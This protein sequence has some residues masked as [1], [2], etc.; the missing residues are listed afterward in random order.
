MRRRS[1]H[2]SEGLGL[3]RAE[4]V[5]RNSGVEAGPNATG[6]GQQITVGIVKSAPAQMNTSSPFSPP[7]GGHRQGYSASSVRSPPPERC[8]HTALCG[9]SD[10]DFCCG[11]GTGNRIQHLCPG[12]AKHTAPCPPCPA[13]RFRCHSSEG[14]RYG[15]RLWNGQN[16][17]LSAGTARPAKG[18]DSPAQTSTHTVPASPDSVFRRRCSRTSLLPSNKDRLSLGIDAIKIIQMD[19]ES[20]L[21]KGFRH[22]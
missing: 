15:N 3:E 2:R 1:S 10:S 11:G 5:Q 14:H 16:I 20:V 17:R 4:K 22:A 8:I 6:D 12:Y 7:P 19:V 18:S 13:V 9:R 21:T